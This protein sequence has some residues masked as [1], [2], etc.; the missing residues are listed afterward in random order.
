MNL[1]FR[2][3]EEKANNNFNVTTAYKVTNEIKIS[4]SIFNK[5]IQKKNKIT[6]RNFIIQIDHFWGQIELF[7]ITYFSNF[8]QFEISI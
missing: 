3:I 5:Q 7:I 4:K 6:I 1:R 8:A 2:R